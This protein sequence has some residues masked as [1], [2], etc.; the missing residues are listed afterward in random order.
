MQIQ[1]KKLS[2]YAAVPDTKRTKKQT[3]K[4]KHKQDKI[5]LTNNNTNKLPT[6]NKH[7]TIT[8]NKTNTLLSKNDVKQLFE[9]K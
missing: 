3:I 9:K 2:L 4:N 5:T 7:N 6:T 8:S 1:I